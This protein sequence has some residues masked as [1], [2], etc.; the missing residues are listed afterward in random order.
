[1]KHRHTHKTFVV[2][3]LMWLW[4]LISIGIYCEAM[5]TILKDTI[6]EDK[7]QLVSDTIKKYKNREAVYLWNVT[8]REAECDMDTFQQRMNWQQYTV[9]YKS[10]HKNSLWG[11]GKKANK[12]EN[13]TSHIRVV[14]QW[15]HIDTDGAK[16]RYKE[17]RFVDEDTL[18][19]IADPDAVIE[20][21]DNGR[22]RRN[23]RVRRNDEVED[24]DISNDPPPNIRRRVNEGHAVNVSRRS[25]ANNV[26]QQVPIVPIVANDNNANQAIIHAPNDAN[27][28]NI[29]QS[30]PNV[31]NP[32]ANNINQPIVHAP[33]PPP[34]DANANNINQSVPNVVNP[35]T[36]VNASNAM[37]LI[38]APPVSALSSTQ[39]NILLNYI[40][41]VTTAL[42][43]NQN[44]LHESI[45]KQPNDTASFFQEAYDRI[46]TAATYEDLCD[47]HQVFELKEIE[48]GY[49][50]ICKLCKGWYIHE[51]V[52]IPGNA[53]F[54]GGGIRMTI[55][56][57]RDPSYYT[58][59]RKWS[60]RE[61]I[62]S[63]AKHQFG[64][65]LLCNQCVALPVVIQIKAE[66]AYTVSLRGDV[67]MLYEDLIYMQHRIQNIINPECDGDTSRTL[68]HY[69][70]SFKNMD[71]WR[72]YLFSYTTD[73][74]RLAMSM[75]T[76]TILRVNANQTVERVLD[77]LLYAGSIDGWSRGH[78][79]FEVI[80]VLTIYRGRRTINPLDFVSFKYDKTQ[81]VKNAIKTIEIVKKT[82]GNFSL[83]TPKIKYDE[84]DDTPYFDVQEGK[85]I[86]CCLNWVSDKPYLSKLTVNA[87]EVVEVDEELRRP[88]YINQLFVTEMYQT[89]LW[90]GW[91]HDTT[92]KREI[93]R[94][95]A[96][97][98]VDEV[99]NML[100][101]SNEAAVAF[102]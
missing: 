26:N 40:Q 12:V 39:N 61:H 73:N 100:V 3:V 48:Y 37:A 59:Q 60:I 44:T 54:A 35:I 68:G 90:R 36:N 46:E 76:Y 19:L 66:M 97:K 55:E 58:R 102:R 62:K 78:M 47:D 51:D 34:N 7:A 45:T 31:V 93:D 99:R 56:E 74:L 84:T 17:Y 88:E 43:H 10:K 85:P 2:F 13:I 42:V 8:C 79:H 75:S 11:G 89:P 82:L 80:V 33:I 67:D 22:V 87:E 50:F 29:N 14:S 18:E 86:P 9:H 77:L 23:E 70:H 24:A 38:P 25:N 6:D 83:L 49:E 30:A 57:S 71:M 95:N 98:E 92:H 28:N 5:Q 91:H 96:A 32:I 63:A 94:K 72:Q 65:E 20:Q 52:R 1:M 69:S 4:L 64:E 41:Q 21:D 27:A 15:R 81:P 16:K 53:R 101:H